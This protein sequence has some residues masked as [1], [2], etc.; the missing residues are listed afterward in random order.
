M[1][2]GAGAR[3]FGLLLASALTIAPAAASLAA[4]AA[5]QIDEGLR[6]SFGRAESLIR[7]GDVES[8]LPLLDRVIERFGTEDAGLRGADRLLLQRS[9]L[10]RAL[11]KWSQGTREVNDDLDRL[12]ELDPTWVIDEDQAPEDLRERFASRRARKVGYLRIALLPQDAN[13]RVD[14]RPLDG[15]PDLVPVLAGEHVVSAERFGYA[16]ARAEVRVRA[17]RTEGVALELQRSSATIQVATVPAGA[18]V[19]VDGE[20]VGQTPASSPPADA[21][22]AV[23]SGPVRVVGLLPGWHEVEVTLAN[24]R[25]FRQR[26]ELP[27]L[28]D[29]DLGVVTLE[30]ALGILVLRD[31]PAEAVVTVDGERQEVER[32]QGSAGPLNTGPGRLVLTVGAHAI[33]ITGP[34][35]GVY[36]ASIVVPDGDTVGLDVRVRPG[37]GFLGVLGGDELDNEGVRSSLV[38]GLSGLEDWFLLDRG[39]DG[40][41][42][43]SQGGVDR[44]RL[45]AVDETGAGIDWSRVQAATAGAVPAGLF[46]V[47]VLP[48]EEPAR[49]FDVWVWTAAPGPAVGVRRR[50]ALGELDAVDDLLADFRAP[51]PRMRSWL[52]ATPMDGTPGDGLPLVAV[53]PSGP[54]ARAGLQVGDRVRT[55]D[56]APVATV[57]QLRAV[58]RASSA[59]GGVPL[60]LTRAGTAMDVRLTLGSSPSVPTLLAPSLDPVEWSALA[61]AI[62]GG[63]WE[64]PVWALELAQARLLMRARQFVDA[65]A[66]LGRIDAPEGA[67]FGRAAVDYWLGLALLAVSEPDIEG[68]RQAFARAAADPNA[69]LFDN[70]GP[71]VQPRALARLA[72][73]EAGEAGR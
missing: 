50:I 39:V 32:Q 1:R 20:L 45:R 7:G 47:A 14:G 38:S 41:V 22:D 59:F 34:G 23:A 33:F 31:L 64:V 40:E 63:T 48:A 68:A 12:V 62:A 42:L 9:L 10:Y 61:A 17:E 35:G 49:F 51:L 57:S 26:I 58:L 55:A 18:T 15:L 54:A 11:A 53:D 21:A 71:R 66:L 3:L 5:P 46:M 8:A 28:G 30:R 37:I 27:N 13:V 24:H 44:E 70:D 29:F 73:L 67:P 16:T 6:I 72:A 69:R 25:P 60:G 65:A 43:L 36:E 2:A 19:V 4:A 56:G 52:G